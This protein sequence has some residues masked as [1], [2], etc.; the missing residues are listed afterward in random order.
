MEEQPLGRRPF[1]CAQLIFKIWKT[2]LLRKRN[3]E[4]IFARYL[5]H[6]L[7]AGK[8]AFFMGILR[9]EKSM[10]RCLSET[11]SELSTRGLEVRPHQIHHALRM[12]RIEKPRLNAAL[13]Y[14]FNPEQVNQL[15]AYFASPVRPGRPKK[16]QDA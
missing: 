3:R 6:T 12:G 10:D 15:E 8:R 9:E 4:I 11:I 13:N 14:L 1:A 16:T 5:S 2:G 7:V